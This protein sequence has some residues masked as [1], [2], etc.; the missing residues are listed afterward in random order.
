M[1]YL[2]SSVTLQ[3]KN[4]SSLLL[5]W[6]LLIANKVISTDAF[7][8]AKTGRSLANPSHRS[9]FSL[10]SSDFFFPLPSDECTMN[11]LLSF[12]DHTSSTTKNQP[13]QHRPRFSKLRSFLQAHLT[14]RKTNK[15]NKQEQ[16]QEQNN[17]DTI[18]CY[19]VNYDAFENEGAAPEVMCTANPEEF[20]WYHGLDVDEM[21]NTNDMPS[22]HLDFSECVEGASHRGTPEWECQQALP[23]EEKDEDDK[24]ENFGI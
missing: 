4:Y 15:K 5:L 10:T 24:W 19:I 2:L 6:S 22:I 8:Q 17:N 12:T 16:E 18:Q 14:N 3:S 20:A 21:V 23:E 9:S 11:S 1:T 13:K 7:L